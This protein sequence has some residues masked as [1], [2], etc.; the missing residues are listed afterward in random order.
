VWRGGEMP[1]GGVPGSAA[2]RGCWWPA[3]GGR[4]L[5]RRQAAGGCRHPTDARK[6]RLRCCPCSATPAASPSPSP[7]QR[8]RRSS[9]A[10][11]PQ[12]PAPHLER[13]V[14]GGVEALV[15]LP[16]LLAAVLV[17]D[18]PGVVVHGG[19]VQGA[20]VRRLGDERRV[21]GALVGWWCWGC[22]GWVGGWVGGWVLRVWGKGRATAEP[23]AVGAAWWAQPGVPAPCLAAQQPLLLRPQDTHPSRHTHLRPSAPG[24]HQRLTWFLMLSLRCATASDHA[25]ISRTQPRLCLACAWLSIHADHV[26]GGAAGAAGAVR[27]RAGPGMLETPHCSAQSC[28]HPGRQAG[29]N[30]RAALPA[31]CPPPSQ[32]WRP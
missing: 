14:S 28:A 19:L 21:L 32:A 8:P 5:G 6:C 15:P 13:I 25:Y 10:R 16:H 30:N 17:D 9:P 1:G 11:L 7:Q 26:C 31:A 18:A 22:Q 4:A 23:G 27:S 2:W 24:T 3:A 12:Q 20:V 29:E